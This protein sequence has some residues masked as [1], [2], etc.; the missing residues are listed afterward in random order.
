[1]GIIV[2]MICDYTEYHYRDEKLI[3]NTLWRT[4]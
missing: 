3:I 4:Q 2:V 1:M